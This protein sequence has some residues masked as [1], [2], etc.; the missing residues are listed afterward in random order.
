MISNHRLNFVDIPKEMFLLPYSLVPLA[1]MDRFMER[2]ACLWIA[3]IFQLAV[4]VEDVIAAP[5]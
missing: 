3:P 2:F 5:L 1:L 4:A